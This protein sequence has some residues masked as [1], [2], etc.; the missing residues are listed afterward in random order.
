MTATPKASNT[1]TWLKQL[2]TSSF[3]TMRQQMDRIDFLRR[4]QKALASILVC[5]ILLVGGSY[6][7]CR[8]AAERHRIQ[9]ISQRA[10]IVQQ[11]AAL[12]APRLLENDVLALTRETADFSKGAQVLF[13]AI[14]NHEN[15]IVAHSNDAL[16]N[17]PYTPLNGREPVETPADTT[18]EKG[19][20]PDGTLALSFAQGIRFGGVQIGTAIHA[21]PYS[22]FRDA[23]RRFQLYQVLLFLFWSIAGGA[24][25]LVVNHSRKRQAT[26]RL[27][28]SAD[29][30]QI[31]PYRLKEKIAQG[32]MAQLFVADYERE[33]G[34]KRQMAIKMVL[35]HLAENQDFIKM[36]I[37]EARLA[38]L[39]QHPNIVQ[40]FD[41][42]K[43]QNTYF[44]AMEYI[45]GVNLGQIISRLQAPMPTDMAVFIIMCV[46]LGLDYSHSRKDDES[47]LAL[48][49]VH[50][51][52]SPQNILISH[53]GEVKIS[54]FGIS[55]ATTEPSFTQAGVIKG[56]LAYLAPEQALGQAVDHRAD[57]YALGLV[58]YEIL[59]GK[60]LYQ[61]DSDI[62]AIRT[63][64]EMEIPPL[65]S[66][67]P[68]LAE[69]LSR[70]VMKCLAKN[71]AERYADALVLYNDLA[72]LKVDLQMPYDTSNLAR[73]MRQTI[74]P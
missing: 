42:G 70:V 32:G 39:L 12:S 62:E 27:Q 5:W 50:R 4:N 9:F 66:V 33:D 67:R 20:L 69:A 31:G 72:Q 65:K 15:R 21:V 8:S 29:G 26:R 36:F 71:K 52:I 51:D 30:N 46:S 48:G 2:T 3:F 68:E 74:N 40:I 60:R 16:F 17:Q 47:G 56:K 7:L 10:A 37:R 19:R 18:V 23:Q 58:F 49:I 55:K 41:F 38:A 63:I 53:Q 73:F 6:L 13:T 24:V 22:L 61:F 34:F 59:T 11:M 54:D 1:L 45:H 14:L 28:V 25:A 35:P 43:I 44:I 57:I 64:P